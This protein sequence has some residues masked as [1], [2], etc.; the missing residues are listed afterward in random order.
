ML[1]RIISLFST[2]FI[3]VTDRCV[4]DTL[5]KNITVSNVLIGPINSFALSRGYDASPFRIWATNCIIALLAP[6]D[7]EIAIIT[8]LSVLRLRDTT[9]SV[10]IA[11]EIQHR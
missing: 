2:P 9:Y 5:D 8:H 3:W 10:R 4:A 6:L 11:S 7:K 1:P